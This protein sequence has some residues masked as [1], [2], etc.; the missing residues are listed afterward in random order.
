[1]AKAPTKTKAEKKEPK[2]GVGTAAR[3][4]ILAGQD[5]DQTLATVQKEF[6]DANTSVKSINWYRNQ[7]RQEGKKVKTAR[8]LKAAKKKAGEAA[9]K[10]DG[11]VV[12][13]AKGKKAA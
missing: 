8:E 5:N 4:A 1:M 12:P 7:L 3:E 10:K 13:I 2:R 6:P 11:K 9:A